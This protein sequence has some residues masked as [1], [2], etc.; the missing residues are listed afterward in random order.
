[1]YAGTRFPQPPDTKMELFDVARTAVTNTAGFLPQT[2]PRQWSV[3]GGTEW[4]GIWKEEIEKRGSIIRVSLPGESRTNAEAE[5]W[6]LEVELQ[7]AAS[8]EHAGTPVSFW[9]E[10]YFFPSFVKIDSG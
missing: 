5:R 7:S 10:I 3:D 6:N 1:M 8:L 2:F 4:L 9:W